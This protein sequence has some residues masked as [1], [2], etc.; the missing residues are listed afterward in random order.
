MPVLSNVQK[1]LDI[2]TSGETTKNISV[3][4]V[5]D[6]KTILFMGGVRIDN[7]GGSPSSAQLRGRLNSTTQ[8]TYNRETTGSFKINISRF[9]AEFTSGIDVQRGSESMSSATR[10]V[11]INAVD[12]AK[13][14]VLISYKVLG[15]N[16][17][18][19]DFVMAQLTSTTNLR[20]E[21]VGTPT[22]GI[23]D[24]QV[25]EITDGL[26]SVQSGLVGLGSGAT[27]VS[28]TLSPAV[29][30]TKAFLIFSYKVNADVDPDTGALQGRINSTTQLT[31][32]RNSSG[33]AVDLS[34]FVVELTDGSTVQ[35][36]EVNLPTGQPDKNVTI[37]SVDTTKTTVHIS[38]L[39]R[40]GENSEGSS[41]LFGKASTLVNLF[42]ATTVKVLRGASSSSVHD[43]VF[44]A[45]EWNTAAVGNIPIFDYHHRQMR[46]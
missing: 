14:F 45:I 17:G 16:F 42:D 23:V 46:H 27:S 5:V 21:T 40:Y 18:D 13:S 7:D 30:L 15:G 44:Y 39:E 6:A 12:L 19:D 38:S 1:S 41:D 33:V 22:S 31:F 9:L 2:V 32:D 36:K 28:D 29:D 26:G 20:L 43:T 10:N 34:W 35:Q 3:T 11:T 24:W 37:T 8:I 4:A 25:I